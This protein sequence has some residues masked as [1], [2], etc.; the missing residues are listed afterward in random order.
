MHGPALSIVTPTYQCGGFVRRTWACLRDQDFTDWEWVVVDDGSTDGTAA[1]LA[2]VARADRQRV[3]VIRCGE[4]RGRG[5]ARAMALEAVRGR[6]VVGWDMDDL[7]FPDRLGRLA[8]AMESGVDFAAS[9]AV[10]V[11]ANLEPVALRGFT[12]DP[13]LGRLFVGA[14]AAVRTDLLRSIGYD[15]AARAG[16]DKRVVFTLAR[17]CRGAYIEEPLYIYFETRA[18]G[19]TKAALDCTHEI[20]LLGEWA[21][22]APAAE[23]PLWRGRLRRL[24]LKRAALGAI[25]LVPGGYK[26]TVALRRRDGLATLAPARRDWLARLRA[27]DAGDDAPRR[28]SR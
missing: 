11:D 5:A 10:L 27:R 17:T 9:H 22:A 8:A 15:S 25:S 23:Q 26:A 20:A 12:D 1:A 4:N 18:A 24:R 7:S 19:V 28:E 6:H 13:L 14:T 3:R 16:E 21:R 2:D